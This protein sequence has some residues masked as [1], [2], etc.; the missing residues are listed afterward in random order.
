LPGEIVDREPPSGP[1]EDPPKGNTEAGLE[2]AGLEETGL[3]DEEAGLE[4]TSLEETGLED[5]EAGLEETG[6]EE[7]GPPTG[8]WSTISPRNPKAHFTGG[9]VF[10]YEF[11]HCFK[12][13]AWPDEAWSATRP[14]FVT[15]RSPRKLQPMHFCMF[16]SEFCSSSHQ[17]K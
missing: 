4:E 13:A 16:A 8:A 11:G 17:A 2:E 10:T 9:V 5:K 1:A 7:T 12:A 14:A 6:L 15:K 3:E